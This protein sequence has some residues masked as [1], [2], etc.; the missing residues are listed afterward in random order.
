[1]RSIALQMMLTRLLLAAGLA[2]MVL[3]GLAVA[4]SQP[5]LAVH[6]VEVR[7]TGEPLLAHSSLVQAQEQGLRRL[8]GQHLEQP[9][10]FQPLAGL[11][12][13][14]QSLPWVRDVVLQRVWPDRLVVGLELHRPA[15]LITRTS[16]TR[17]L[18]DQGE[19]LDL[20]ARRLQALEEAMGC[21]IVRAEG[22]AGAEQLLLERAR[23][24]SPLM[25]Q[26]GVA[27]AQL[28]LTG[29]GG[30]QLTTS[31]GDVL[32]LGRDTARPS[33]AQRLSRGFAVLAAQRAGVEGSAALRIDLRYASGAAIQRL[34][35]ESAAG[36]SR[37]PCPVHSRSVHVA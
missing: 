16:G 20:N 28:S 19:Q 15:L 10:V 12:Q 36:P 22:P 1:M 23:E 18:N 31:R 7:L 37:Q 29:P 32:I 17:L 14:L 27:I 13:E 30:W 8:L 25:Q 5:R 4:L 6:Q 3:A 35:D 34:P 33:L 2:M 11:R 24:L 21:T 26:Q 9:L